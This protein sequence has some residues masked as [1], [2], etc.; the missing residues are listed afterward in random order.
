[1]FKFKT[2]Y[3]KIKTLLVSVGVIFLILFLILV[4]YK[5]K[6]EK[7]IMKSSQEQMM[8][9]ISSLLEMNKEKTI[10]LL[11][12]NAYWDELIVEIEKPDSD[13]FKTNITLVSTN[14][15]DYYCFYN[16]K[17]IPVQKEHNANL[18]DEMV[19]PKEGLEL[20][21]QKRHLHFFQKTPDGLIEVSAAS[22]HPS[23]D[24]ESKTTKPSGYMIL[25]KKWDQKY[26]DKLASTSGS[27]ISLLSVSDT[28]ANNKQNTIQTK[29]K[30]SSWDGTPV[31]VLSFTREIQLN[32]YTTQNIMYIILAFVMFTLLFANFIA[33]RCINTPLMLVTDILKTDN[34]ESISSLKTKDAE[35]GRIGHLFETYVQQ[36]QELQEA[37]VQAEKSDKLKSAFLANMSHEIRTPMNSILGFSELLEEEIKEGQ[38]AEYLNLIQKNGASL[39]SLISDMID[40]AKIE[41]GDLSVSNATFEID[42]LFSELKEI[43]SQEL[44]RRRKNEVQIRYHLPENNLILCSDP[45]LIKQVL[46]NLLSNS[47]KFTEK[48]TITFSCE[49]L[50]NEFVF[51]VSDTGTGIPEDD[52]K[53]IFERF[54]KFNYKWLNSEGTGIGLSIVEKIVDALNGRIWLESSVGKGTSFHFS[55][56]NHPSTKTQSNK[57]V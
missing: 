19:F 34:K 47:T 4:F 44:Y 55:V 15:Y 48:G 1:M 29:I 7:A 25:A 2:I 18:Q 52:Q 56:P 35:Y 40:L 36:K 54:T 30:F 49:K 14:F 9:E 8:H 27:T 10:Q 45:H 39:L 6:Q 22:V 13:W 32:F 46:S 41:A 38:A 21:N 28:I 33:R 3:G 24:F 12:D 16:T 57:F 31:C 26:L 20:L 43:Y 51:S 23:D 5:N 42:E 11:N 17:Y 50:E 37:K 53:R